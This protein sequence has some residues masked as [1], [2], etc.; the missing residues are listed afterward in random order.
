[1]SMY[2]MNELTSWNTVLLDKDSELENRLMA[3][4][5]QVVSE[6]WETIGSIPMVLENIKKE[7]TERT[8]D[9]DTAL[10]VLDVD[11]VMSKI[12]VWYSNWW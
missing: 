11:D 5:G 7:I 4:I 1:M 12:E 9:I 6:L 3:Y 10:N 2:K 8:L